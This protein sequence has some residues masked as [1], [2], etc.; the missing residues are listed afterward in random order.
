MDMGYDSC[1]F[2]TVI[3]GYVSK[4]G[5]RTLQLGG[6]DLDDILLQELRQDNKE[7]Q[8]TALEDKDYFDTIKESLFVSQ[9]YLKDIPRCSTFAQDFSFPVCGETFTISHNLCAIPEALFQ[10]L[11]YWGDKSEGLADVLIEVVDFFATS[12]NK[13]THKNVLVHGGLSSIPGMQDRIQ[14]E[15]N[16]NSKTRHSKVNNLCCTIN[17]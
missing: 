7:F 15:L 2:T 10:P 16:R 14:Y 6:R 13:F 8:P 12:Q 1:R 17:F 5:C 9:D 4:L 11:I 3:D